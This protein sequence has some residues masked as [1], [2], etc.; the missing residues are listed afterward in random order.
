MTPPIALRSQ[1]RWPWRGL[2]TAIIALTILALVVVAVVFGTYGPKLKNDAHAAWQG[3]LQVMADD[4]TRAIEEW[5]TLNFGACETLASFPVVK[6]LT[7]SADASTRSHAE[8]TLKRTA[9]SMLGAVFVVCDAEGQILASTLEGINPAFT[10]DIARHAVKYNENYGDAVRLENHPPQIVFA[11]PIRPE[12]PTEKLLGCVV[13]ISDPSHFLFPLI[14]HEPIAGATTEVMIVRREGEFVRYLSPLRHFDNSLATLTGSLQEQ[15]LAATQALTGG[16]AFDSSSDYREQDVLAATRLVANMPWGLI[17]KVDVDEALAPAIRETRIFALVSSLFVVS[18]VGLAMGVVVWL[19]TQLSQRARQ[20]EEAL[21]QSLS[22]ASDGI[23]FLDGN[24]YIQDARGAIETLYHRRPSDLIGRHFDSL[25]DK[26]TAPANEMTWARIGR[27]DTVMREDFNTRDDGTTFWGQ[28]SIRNITYK[29]SPYFLCIVRDIT[30]QKSAEASQKALLDE[31]RCLEMTLEES[32]AVA[33]QWLPTADWKVAY[34]SK[35]V[36][37]FGYTASDFMSGDIPYERFIH[38]DD[39]ARVSEEVTHNVANGDNEYEQS[40]RVICRDGEIRWLDDRTSVLRNE[41]GEVRLYQGVLLDIT[42]RKNAEVALL[43]STNQLRAMFESANCALVAIDAN[44]HYRRWN[45]R[46]EQ[47][48]QVS[49]DQLQQS[50][51]F[52]QTP[53]NEH[54]AFRTR[55]ARL[56]NGELDQYQVERRFVRTDGSILWGDVSVT[57]MR[58]PLGNVVEYLAVVVDITAQKTANAELYRLQAAITQADEVIMITD[59]RGNIQYANPAFERVT[60]YDLHEVIGKKTSLL[61][62]ATHS[63]D[64]YD[65]LWS[66]ILGGHVWKGRFTNQRKDGSLFEVESSI[67]PMRDEHGTINSFIAVNRDVTHERELEKQLMQSQKLEA[68][69]TLAGGIAHDFN[70]ILGAI[71]GYTELAIQEVEENQQVKDDLQH[72]LTASERARDLIQQILVFS[73]KS[74][75]VRAPV[76]IHLIVKEAVKLLRASIPASI[77]I[78]TDI[79]R[80]AG[81]VH[82]DPTLIHQI[83]VNLCTNA[84]HAMSSSAHGTLTVTL[85]PVDVTPEMVSPALQVTPGRFALLRVSD[86]GCGM[87]PE[88]RERIFEPFFTTKG[89][90]EGT[91]MGLSTVH[92]IVKTHDGAILVESTPGQG[93]VFEVYLPQCMGTSQAGTIDDT[94]IIEGQGEHVLIVDDE[95]ALSNMLAKTLERVGYRVSA[96]IDSRNALALFTQSPDTF[97]V[98]V[99]DLT[100]PNMTGRELATAIRQIRPDIPI[101]VITGNADKLGTD[102]ELDSAITRC[103]IKP[104]RKRQLCEALADV[105]RTSDEHRAE[106]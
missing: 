76:A 97:D 100:M 24:G 90:G 75:H 92:G 53:L 43:E 55:I 42:D 71:L 30:A 40:Y 39:L 81:L 82:S 57:A 41:T 69:G 54:E 106:S 38:P 26:E 85:G 11:V 46:W 18:I 51:I 73:R 50:T 47:M 12:I 64:F 2:L 65:G 83:A 6:A 98:I 36:A 95:P 63:E 56:A 13:L 77:E 29:Q 59:T 28:V 22:H 4:R 32:P 15:R 96:C 91:G 68:I 3:H 1:L 105:L 103:L 5:V 37:Q 35:N 86:T 80:S 14:V 79:D 27:D 93:S 45:R 9:E 16:G 31:M 21:V 72:V 34:V 62:S 104:V 87:S 94:P 20:V 61:R 25:R 67:S 44:F 17:A 58:D 33:I 19:R 99:T 102:S 52:D 70:N 60:G 8:N 88:I 10:T 49:G 23:F 66:T 84:F 48:T 7:N 89:I 74:E 101:I 78:V